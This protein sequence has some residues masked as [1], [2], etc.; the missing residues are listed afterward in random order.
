MTRHNE[1]VKNGPDVFVAYCN[2]KDTRKEFQ[3]KKDLDTYVKRHLKYCTCHTS[4][5]IGH[6]YSYGGRR[7]IVRAV[8]EE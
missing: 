5:T 8:L 3:C 1:E 4:S 6:E 7:Q 2:V